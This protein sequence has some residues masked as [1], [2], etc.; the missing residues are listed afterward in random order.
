M[1]FKAVDVAVGVAIRMEASGLDGMFEY[2]ENYSFP[3]AKGKEESCTMELT[4]DRS[5]EFS[6]PMEPCE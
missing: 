5:S 3:L 6:I 4:I 2:M 1:Q